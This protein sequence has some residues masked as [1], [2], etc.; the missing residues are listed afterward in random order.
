MPPFHR[1]LFSNHILLFDLI[2]L[3]DFFGCNFFNVSAC[4]LTHMYKRETVETKILRAQALVSR[5]EREFDANAMR[6]IEMAEN[7]IFVK[8][9]MEE[10]TRQ[11]REREKE[12]FT[13]KAV[14]SNAEKIHRILNAEEDPADNQESHITTSDVTTFRVDAARTND[15]VPIPVGVWASKDLLSQTE[16]DVDAVNNQEP[17][18]QLSSRRLVIS[19]KSIN[20][21]GTPKVMLPSVL[22]QSLASEAGIVAI[23]GNTHPLTSSRQDIA[24]ASRTSCSHDLATL[25]NRLRSNDGILVHAA[26]DEFN[27]TQ[28]ASVFEPAVKV[29]S[30]ANGKLLR[31]IFDPPKGTPHI[32]YSTQRWRAKQGIMEMLVS[33]R[34][35]LEGIAEMEC[36]MQQLSRSI[37]QERSR[38]ENCEHQLAREKQRSRNLSNQ[39]HA[40]LEK[41]RSREQHNVVAAISV[42]NIAMYL[43]EDDPSMSTPLLKRI[44]RGDGGVSETERSCIVGEIQRVLEFI[45]SMNGG[46]DHNSVATLLDD[47]NIRRKLFGRFSVTNHHLM[48]LQAMSDRETKRAARRAIEHKM[49][50]LESIALELEDS[51]SGYNQLFV[52]GENVY[53][54]MGAVVRVLSEEQRRDVFGEDSETNQFVELTKPRDAVCPLC[55]FEFDATRPISEYAAVIEEKTKKSTEDLHHVLV[56]RRAASRGG[57]PTGTMR[58]GSS[59]RRPNSTTDLKSG[60]SRPTTSNAQMEAGSSTNN[61]DGLASFEIQ[62]AIMALQQIIKD[63]EQKT[64]KLQEQVDEGTAALRMEKMH[65]ATLDSKYKETIRETGE[66]RKRFDQEMK[67][68]ADDTQLFQDQAEQLQATLNEKLCRIDDLEEINEELHH[69][70]A[71][72]MEAEKQ[73]NTIRFGYPITPEQKADLSFQEIGYVY[74]RKFHECLGQLNSL[75]KRFRLVPSEEDDALAKDVGIMVGGGAKGV[76]AVKHASVSCVSKDLIPVVD[77]GVQQESDGAE[78]EVQTDPVPSLRDNV[79]TD[80]CESQTEEYLRRMEFRSPVLGT[81]TSSELVEVGTLEMGKIVSNLRD[82]RG[83]LDCLLA[84]RTKECDGLASVAM[85][86][87]LASHAE[88]KRQD[89]EHHSQLLCEK[90]ALI[91]RISQAYAELQNSVEEAQK[92]VTEA[93]V[94]K[95]SHVTPLAAPLQRQSSRK[96]SGF[97]GGG[98]GLGTP[99]GAEAAPP[100]LD[101]YAQLLEASLASLGD[102]PLDCLFVEQQEAALRNAL[103]RDSSHI[104]VPLNLLVHMFA[105][106]HSERRNS[107]KP[108]CSVVNVGLQDLQRSKHHST[109]AKRKLLPPLNREDASLKLPPGDSRVSPVADVAAGPSAVGG[110]RKGGLRMFDFVSLCD[111]GIDERATVPASHQSIPVPPLPY[112]QV[113]DVMFTSDAQR[114]F[115]VRP[116]PS[117]SLIVKALGSKSDA[118]SPPPQNSEAP[119]EAHKGTGHK[120]GRTTSG[121]PSMPQRKTFV[122]PQRNS[123][124]LLAMRIQSQLRI[125]TPNHDSSTE[126]DAMMLGSPSRSHEENVAP[127]VIDGKEY[128]M[129]SFLAR[130]LPQFRGALPPQAL[131]GWQ[132]PA[133]GFVD[134]WNDAVA[135][136]QKTRARC[137]AVASQ[138]AAA[139]AARHAAVHWSYEDDAEMLDDT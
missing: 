16:Y 20:T 134:G 128:E 131:V 70:M 138:V 120:E 9:Q 117:P 84:R 1:L 23:N 32:A 136:L 60:S 103:I 47:E 5:V 124:A 115:E 54:K 37:D 109:S 59:F 55:R 100:L 41:T 25:F 13:G 90:D 111:D 122:P 68:A 81:T 85:D 49:A 44:I 31:R 10:V 77:R 2:F 46:D 137:A 35:D 82:V 51:H 88:E 87:V 95:S 118:P 73:V 80:D 139:N 71:R 72:T 61:G 24:L 14:V 21:P 3:F 91:Q 99:S 19:P 74:Y 58:S 86:A 101:S 7:D 106:L 15:S 78:R 102:A 38:R 50:A 27:S 63:L 112:A 132:K 66:Y 11:Q 76:A 65:Y 121:P 43:P 48:A 39:L 52:V 123:A 42:G 28:F 127:T 133:G 29:L 17:D 45:G 64:V 96:F 22:E 108:Q 8:R 12:K 56:G 40:A 30:L 98:G 114:R 125:G 34:F 62:V 36:A 104:V 130:P 69:K 89:A 92:N 113:R 6:R 97:F 83:F 116:E 119:V 53:A 26:M 110:D 105:S 75:K 129:S 4:G 18:G 135:S 79:P 107:R 67:R 57:D 93:P 94:Q 33:G 126:P